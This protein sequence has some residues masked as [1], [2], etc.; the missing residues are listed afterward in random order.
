MTLSRFIPDTFTLI[1]CAVIAL[2]SLFPCEGWGATFFAHLTTAA[3]ALLF[4]MHGAKLSRDAIVAGAGHWR[5]HLLVFACTFVLFPI[6]GLA[7][8]PVLVP[9]IGQELYWGILYICALP[10]TVQ[11][12]IAFTSLAKGNVAAAIC[13]AAASSLIGVFLTPLLVGLLM[14]LQGGAGASLL[15]AVGKITLQLLVPFMLGQL[16]RPWLGGWIAQHV[17]WLRHVDQGS[18]LLVVYTAF[19]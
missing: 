10:A 6:I 16:A 15:D 12:A 5:L 3:I 7:L 14:G 17:Q 13:S 2:A 19:S 8:R 11:S 18:I 1:L 9:W 4:F